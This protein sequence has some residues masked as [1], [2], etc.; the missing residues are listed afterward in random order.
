MGELPTLSGERAIPNSEFR[1][2]NFLV[3]NFL[4]PNF[5]VPNFLVPNFLVPNFHVP[6]FPSSF[7]R[8]KQRLRV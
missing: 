5:L 7:E 4:V 2:P 6:N 3:P 1:I 8:K